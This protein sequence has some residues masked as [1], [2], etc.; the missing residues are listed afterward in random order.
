MQ[1]L[2]RLAVI[3]FSDIVGYTAMMQQ[4][5]SLALV[6]LNRFKASL[7]HW[8]KEFRGE[9]IQYYGDGGLVIFTNSADAVNCAST[10]QVEFRDEPQVPVR[11]GIHSG[12]IIHNVGNIFGDSVNIASRIESMGIAGAV[13]ISD[14]IQKQIKNK[15][16]FKFTSLGNFKFKNVDEPMEILALAINNFPVPKRNEM[17]GKFKE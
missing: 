9:V 15:P 7:N 17:D 2:R 8:V 10:L 12:D 6:K 13:L 4:N 14:S 1:E 16:Q 11:I 3:M 5:E